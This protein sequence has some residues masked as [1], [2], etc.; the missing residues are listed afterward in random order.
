MQP[1]RNL[2]GHSGVVAYELGADSIRVWFVNGKNYRY[3]AA[4]AG[5]EHVRT[6]QDLAQTGK[7]L[8]GYISKHVHDDYD[9]DV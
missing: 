4:N 9:R 8:A 7:G 6:M 2:D 5:V 3:S 1:Y